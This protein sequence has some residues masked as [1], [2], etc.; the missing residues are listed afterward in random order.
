MKHK[1]HTELHRENMSQEQLLISLEKQVQELTVQLSER[2]EK[3]SERDSQLAEIYMSKEW[4]M[5]QLLRKAVGWLAPPNSWR[6]KIGQTILSAI[7][8]IDFFWNLLFLNQKHTHRKRGA[9]RAGTGYYQNKNS[10]PK[11]GY[12]ISGT[13]ISG[14]VAVV[15]E[16]VNR[17][18]TRG[19]DVSIISEDNLDRIAWFPNQSAPVIP[20]ENIS[21]DAFDILVAT[22]WTTAYTVQKLDADRKFYFV[23]S[24]ERRFYPP[25]DFRSK[26]AQKTYTMDF[27]FITMARWLQNWLKSE[28]GRDSAYVPNGIN[29]QIIYPDKPVEKK[30]RVLRV[31]LEG[32]INAPYKGMKDAFMAVSGLDCEVWCVSASGRP[33]TDWKC[34]KFFTKV[35]FGKMRH[36]YSS[37][38]ILL[39]MS[40]VESFA[41]PPLEMMAC[42]GTA[43]VGKVTGIEEYIVNGYNALV[44]DQGDIQGAHNALKILI[45]DEKLRNELIE[46]GKKTAE[47]FRWDPSIDLLENIFSETL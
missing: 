12:V 32:S 7:M 45:E 2:E 5:V 16:H 37:C 3:L 46:N 21:D 28:F 15:C 42:G 44:V 29:E 11:I 34:D 35:P 41:Y 39:K 23:Q 38:D 25:A 14:G 4:K 6:E 24:D 17:L 20:L 9:R 22:G 36:I 19:Y 40:R 18:M 31:L 30:G 33:E 43:V 10:R 8:G 26:R 27:R 47:K 1:K 13:A